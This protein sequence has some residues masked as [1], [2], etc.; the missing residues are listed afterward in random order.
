MG[1][2]LDKNKVSI[3]ALNVL[4]KNYPLGPFHTDRQ[5]H[6]LCPELIFKRHY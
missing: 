5:C 2:I 6:R 1:K 3:H 4:F